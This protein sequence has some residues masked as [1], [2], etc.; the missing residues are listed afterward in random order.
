MTSGHSGSDKVQPSSYDVVF[1]RLRRRRCR[2]SGPVRI[3]RSIKNEDRDSKFDR[4]SRSYLF[5]F[6]LFL[7]SGVKKLREV[8]VNRFCR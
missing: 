4:E 5:S 2:A 7:I 6:V 3:Q 8:G 1:R